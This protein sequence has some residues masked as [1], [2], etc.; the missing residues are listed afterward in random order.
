MNQTADFL[1][2]MRSSSQAR[3]LAAKKIV[4]FE[5]LERRLASLDRAPNLRPLKLNKFSVIAEVKRRSPAMGSLNQHALS[6]EKRVAT[7]VES[8]ASIISVLT[9]PER[10]DGELSDLE[11]AYPVAGAVPLMR[12]DFIVDPYQVSEA[13]LAGASGVL[14]IVRMLSVKS[15]IDCLEQAQR[16]GLFVLLELFDDSEL[17]DLSSALNSWTQDPN[18]C[19]IGVNSRNLATLEVNLQH[20]YHMVNQLPSGHPK[21][22]ESGLETPE[23]A[24]KLAQAGYDAALV[25]GALMRSIQPAALLKDMIL[26]GRAGVDHRS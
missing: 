13:R 14:L 11:N 5:S 16:L 25:G 1:E 3:V 6:L 15:L 4:S 20:L 8:G 7:Y 26:S 22:A 24:Y 18:R 9:E 21:V 17:R 10:F 23:D 2:Y 12:K 19:L